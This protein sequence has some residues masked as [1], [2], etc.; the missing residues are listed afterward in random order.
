MGYPITPSPINATFICDSL[1]AIIFRFLSSKDG[2][3]AR[4]SFDYRNVSQFLRIYQKGILLKNNEV[5]TLA[6]GNRSLLIFLKILVSGT[7]RHRIDRLHY[8]C[9]L[10]GAQHVTT[11]RLSVHGYRNEPHNIGG[12]HRRIVVHR[13][14]NS[15]LD[16]SLYRADKTR[17]LFA[18]AEPVPITPKIR[19]YRIIGWNDSQFF[20]PKQ[21][22]GSCQ[23]RMNCYGTMI[24][25]I[26]AGHGLRNAIDH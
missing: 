15:E 14:G 10:V 16:G 7:L 20:K 6:H 5:C 2:R 13:I 1:S 24:W 11:A 19:V 18:K 17:P 25:Q 26:L 23:L 8:G 4:K 21:L 3:A 22:I 9:P 12:H